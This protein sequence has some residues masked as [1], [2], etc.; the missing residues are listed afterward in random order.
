MTEKELMDFMQETRNRLTDKLG[1][2]REQAGFVIDLTRHYH[3]T[4][5]A[6]LYAINDYMDLIEA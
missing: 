3:T 1:M 4:I 6:A 2:T 5:G